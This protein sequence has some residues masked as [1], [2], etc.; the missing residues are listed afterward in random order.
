MDEIWKRF[1]AWFAS[2]SGGRAVF[3][4]GNPNATGPTGPI[5]L[6]ADGQVNAVDVFDGGYELLSFQQSCDEKHMMDA[7]AKQE[8]WDSSW[9]SPAWFPFASDGA[10]QLLLVEEPS[11]RV[12]E[13]LHDDEGRSV[14]ANSLEE[15][16]AQTLEQLESGK[17]TFDS[18]YGVYD[19]E[20][21]RLAAERTH[22]KSELEAKYERRKKW[23]PLFLVIWMI[24]F[25]AFIIALERCR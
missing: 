6:L 14:L 24:P 8:G 22:E 21:R 18:E 4:P 13:F 10:G 12:F 11:G 17:L 19:P 1:D 9:W 15:F 3:R 5:H 16:V 20:L 2:K 25:V 7:L 23:F